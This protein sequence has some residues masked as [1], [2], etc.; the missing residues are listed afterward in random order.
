MLEFSLFFFSRL[1]PHHSPHVDDEFEVEV[2]QH[3]Y[4]WS[5]RAIM[6]WLEWDIRGNTHRVVS[7]YPH[8]WVADFAMPNLSLVCFDHAIFIYFF[9]SIFICAWSQWRNEGAVGMRMGKEFAPYVFLRLGRIVASY[10]E[11]FCLFVFTY[12]YH[13]DHQ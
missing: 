13:Y 3:T 12:L 5:G 2:E 6:A 9:F 7:Y 1:G 10:W 11:S 8:C 4:F